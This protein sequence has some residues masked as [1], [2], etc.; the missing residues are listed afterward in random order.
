MLDMRRL[1]ASRSPSSPA[2]ARTRAVGSAEIITVGIPFCVFKLLTGLVLTQGSMH[3]AVM[4]L[5]YALLALGTADAVVNLV[6]LGSLFVRGRRL[7]GVCLTEIVLRRRDGSTKP[8][9]VGVAVDVFISFVLVAL[10]I[11]GGLLARMPR[12]ALSIWNVAVV[13]NVL[14]AGIGRLLSAIARRKEAQSQL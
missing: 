1:S 8:D 3:A 6:N 9:D 2:R 13:F 11:G 4:V 14:G 5:G 12:W 10:A 7:W